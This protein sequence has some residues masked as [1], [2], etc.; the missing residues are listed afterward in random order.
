M[1]GSEVHSLGGFKDARDHAEDALAHRTYGRALI[2]EAC[3]NPRIVC[4]GAD[5]SQPTETHLFRDLLPDRFFMMG[6]QEA[7]MIGAAAG[8]ARCGDIAF[9]HSFC[10]FITRRVYDQVAMQVAYPKLNVKL[11]GFI[12]GLCTPLGVSHQAI[13]DIA[14]MRALPNMAVI[15]PSGPEQ[16]AAA[17]RAAVAHEGPVYLR[18][19]VATAREDRGLP[20]EDFTLGRG[21]I[22]RE[23]GD[24]AILACGDRVQAAVIAGERLADEGLEATVVNMASLKPFDSDLAVKLGRSHRVLVT[25][26]NHSVIGGL[27]AAAAEALALAGANP[28]F[29]M[30]GVRDVFAEGGSTDFLSEKYGL[31]ADDIVRKAMDLHRG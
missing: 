23:G 5:L 7:N 13:D 30:I 14:L 16:V 18:L 29:G 19:Q 27:G 8:M 6:I 2:A 15:E 24:V 22:L 11:A 1:N 12:P 25:A 26:E 20:I 17:V 21:R 31:T 3:N 9:A 10:V 4:L 28:H